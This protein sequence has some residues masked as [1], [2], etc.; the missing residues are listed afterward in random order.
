M[1]PS[2]QVSASGGN[3]RM[4][5]VIGAANAADEVDPPGARLV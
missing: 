4:L 3:D 2:A 5:Q 1:T